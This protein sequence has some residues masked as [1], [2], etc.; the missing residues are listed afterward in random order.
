MP[1]WASERITSVALA[2]RLRHE[3][4]NGP[5]WTVTK[6]LLTQTVIEKGSL[7]S[8]DNGDIACEVK[9]KS[10]GNATST[11]IKW[12]LDDGT[13][14]SKYDANPKAFIDRYIAELSG[15]GHSSEDAEKRAKAEAARWDRVIVAPQDVPQVDDKERARHGV[16]M[17]LDDANLQDQK[18]AQEIV[19]LRAKA[20]KIKAQ[21]KYELDVLDYDKQVKDAEKDI[22]IARL[23]LQK[24]VGKLWN[25]SPE[26]VA[27]AFASLSMP[28]SDSP[29][30]TLAPLLAVTKLECDYLA[31]LE[32]V[33]GKI[34][35]AIGD[36]DAWQER[37]SWSKRMYR[38]GYVSK[39]Q[40]DSDQSKLDSAEYALKKLLTDR[41]ILEVTREL[42]ET[43]PPHRPI[44]ET[45]QSDHHQGQ[46]R[47]SEGSKP[48]RPRHHRKCVQEGNGQDGRPKGSDRQVRRAGAQGRH[49]G[50]LLLAAGPGRLRQPAAGHRPGRTGQRR[51]KDAAHPRHEQDAGAGQDSRGHGHATSAPGKRPRC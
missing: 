47:C 19:V 35:M 36:R 44:A 21:Q 10:S 15:K 48:G 45:P 2:L 34:D 46:G 8:E 31:A 32:D 22:V 5:T 25:D 13:I 50:L 23:N 51:P 27:A 14:V 24:Y 26:T 20:D 40:A 6:Q 29:F 37:A 3:P 12:V 41:Q 42:E 43:T 7:E 18:D 4:F 49:A 28:G 17:L 16:V 33:L 11:T 9:A 38:L 30:G 39:T 1:S